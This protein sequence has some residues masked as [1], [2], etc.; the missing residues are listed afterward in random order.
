VSEKISEIHSADPVEVT[1]IKSTTYSYNPKVGKRGKR[2]RTD[3][4]ALKALALA[5]LT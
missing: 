5:M 1:H 3:K 4:E 2:K